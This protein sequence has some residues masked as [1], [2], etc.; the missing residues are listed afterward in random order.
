MASGDFTQFANETATFAKMRLMIDDVVILRAGLSAVAV[1]VC[2]GF[3]ASGA[4][5]PAGARLSLLAVAAARQIILARMHDSK[6]AAPEAEP[7]VVSSSPSKEKRIPPWKKPFFA[8]WCKLSSLSLFV[9]LLCITLW[10]GREDWLGMHRQG[11]WQAVEDV[12]TLFMPMVLMFWA[13][14]CRALYVDL[15]AMH[16]QASPE[17]FAKYKIL[18]KQKWLGW[19]WQGPLI[20]LIMAWLSG[21]KFFGFDKF[22]A[23][24]VIT[25]GFAV[26]FVAAK[27]VW[28]F[29]RRRNIPRRPRDSE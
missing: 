20:M 18:V 26:V 15:N 22:S 5:L 23:A 24:Y 11:D 16:A 17:E 3:F 25:A 1:I 9:F 19:L 27:A 14:F 12:L 28:F 29:R 6:Q 8:L 4:R 10:L 2:A 13:F 21:D 7:G